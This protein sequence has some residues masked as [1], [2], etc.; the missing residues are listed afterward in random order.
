MMDAP[1]ERRSGRRSHRGRR[2]EIH[3]ADENISDVPPAARNASDFNRAMEQHVIVRIGRGAFICQGDPGPLRASDSLRNATLEKRRIHER[4][5]DLQT[6][7]PKRDKLIVPAMKRFLSPSDVPRQSATKQAYPVE[8][9]EALFARR[10]WP[11]S[12]EQNGQT[13]KRR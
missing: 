2:G 13:Q 3:H 8:L 11:P 5:L 4:R 10:S 12:A 7:G 6:G 9:L 1:K